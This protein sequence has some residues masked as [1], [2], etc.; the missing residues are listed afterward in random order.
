[1]VTTGDSITLIEMRER[2]RCMRVAQTIVSEYSRMNQKVRIFRRNS[3]T[4]TKKENAN[5]Y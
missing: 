5:T 3:I 4:F 1:M 2:S